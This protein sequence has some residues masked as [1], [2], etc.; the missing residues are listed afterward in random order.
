MSEYLPGWRLSFEGTEF[1][2]IEI[3]SFGNVGNRGLAI[4]NGSES[5]LRMPFQGRYSLYL[6]DGVVDGKAETWSLFQDGLIPSESRSV[7]FKVD[8]TLSVPTLLLDGVD[9]PLVPSGGEGRFVIYGADVTAFA[10]REARLTFSSRPERFLQAYSFDSIS[11]SP[12]VV[13]E[14]SSFALIFLG[15][16][17]LAF[18]TRLPDVDGEK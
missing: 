17:C 14:P 12:F 7:F 1:F 10:G 11:F 13:P 4:L 5:R 8:Y 16:F 6:R 3:N 2:S 18:G 9:L 15:I